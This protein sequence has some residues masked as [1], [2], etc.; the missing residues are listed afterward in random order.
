MRKPSSLQ[1]KPK[2]VSHSYSRGNLM[3]ARGGSFLRPETRTYSELWWDSGSVSFGVLHEC[4]AYLNRFPSLALILENLKTPLSLKL[5]IS[6]TSAHWHAI[7]KSLSKIESP[8]RH[9]PSLFGRDPGTLLAGSMFRFDY[10]VPAPV[11]YFWVNSWNYF[12]FRFPNHET[13]FSMP[14]VEIYGLWV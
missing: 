1:P 9:A 4:S 8:L 10:P 3:P 5:M 14:L 7:N 13:S 11:T 2:K 12:Y 6:L